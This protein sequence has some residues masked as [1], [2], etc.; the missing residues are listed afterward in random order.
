[1]LREATNPHQVT[2]VA[3]GSEVSLGEEVRSQL[4]SLGIGARLVSM[5]C[6]LLFD[7]QERAYKTQTLAPHTLRVAIEAA[8]SWGWERYVG[9]RG[10]IF[11][12]D[13]FGASAPYKE[14]YKHFGLTCGPIVEAIVQRL[15]EDK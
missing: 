8:S 10:L 3:T 9:D 15:E 5:P 7:R 14:L 4:E 6:T 2:L 1:M 12:I 13:T 11:G